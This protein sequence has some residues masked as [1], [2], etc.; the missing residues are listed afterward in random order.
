MAASRNASSRVPSILTDM[1][2]LTAV[3]E[4]AAERVGP[5]ADALLEAGAVAVDIADAAAGTPQEQ[6]RF[7]EAGADSGAWDRNRVSALFSPETDVAAAMSRAL[8][9]AGLDAKTAYRVRR[10]DDR[11]WVR[12]TREQFEPIRIS[13]RVWIVPS[14]HAPPDPAAVNIVL[15]PGVAFGTGT[16]PTTRLALRWLEEYV[17]G[18]ESVIDFGCGSGILAIAAL[19]LGA[20]RAWGVDIDAQARLAARNNAVQNRVDARFIAAA[21]EIPDPAD[22]VVAN[23]LANPLVVLAPLLASL[24]AS[25]G[26]IAL[27]GILAQQAE[28]VRAAY[29]PWFE[30]DATAHD[31][32]WVLLSGVRS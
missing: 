27:S 13:P 1:F 10:L 25:R 23:I 7:G 31:E 22:L 6:T 3:I 4:V 30:I 18:G 17:R 8:E 32:D 11:D 24:T 9:A 26:R 2:W 12:V 14:W 19:K 28:D 15:D 21:D 16:H 29:M 20:S 5:F